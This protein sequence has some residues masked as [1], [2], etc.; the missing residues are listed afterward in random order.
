MY[1]KNIGWAQPSGEG[2][3]PFTIVTCDLHETLWEPTRKNKKSDKCII[4]DKYVIRIKTWSTF[5]K[6]VCVISIYAQRPAFC[7]C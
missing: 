5:R 1:K 4:T 2:E 6:A 7:L 3:L